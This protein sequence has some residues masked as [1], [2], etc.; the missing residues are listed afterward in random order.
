MMVAMA[1]LIALSLLVGR[2]DRLQLTPEDEAQLLGLA[3]QQLAAG[4]DGVGE[5]SVST[6]GLGS[7]LLK[8]RS[9]F[10]AL[11]VDGE[12]RGCM[13]DQFEPHEPLYQNVLR[14]TQLAAQADGRVASIDA[15]D[16]ASARIEISVVDRIRQAEFSSPEELLL[17]IT[18]FEDGVILRLGGDIATFLPYVWQTYSDPEEF[19]SELCTKAGWE[20]DRWRRRPYPTVEI[21]SVYVFGE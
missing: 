19:L 5:I 4:A 14:N 18:P 10:V 8:H 7:E 17:R 15:A 13:I 12:M 11:T 1:L 3:R 2:P 21:Y 9:A 16:V 6:V 20:A